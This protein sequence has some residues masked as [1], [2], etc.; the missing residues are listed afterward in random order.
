MMNSD[1]VKLNKKRRRTGLIIV[2]VAFVLWAGYAICEMDKKENIPPLS[3]DLDFVVGLHLSK[4]PEQPF[5][6]WTGQQFRC[7]I[8]KAT[9]HDDE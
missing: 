4:Q 9:E 7:L 8:N 2:A 3:K 5:R 6:D 1:H